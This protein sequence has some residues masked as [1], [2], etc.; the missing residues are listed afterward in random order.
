[1][2]DLILSVSS[3]PEID[4]DMFACWVEGKSVE[5]TTQLKL[6]QFKNSNNLLGLEF[7]RARENS[8]TDQSEF[9]RYEVLDQYRSF[10]ILEHYLAQPCLV[11]GQSLVI[12]T[13]VRS[14]IS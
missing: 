10:D 9:I 8:S 3:P 11:N 5:E 1:M 6:E 7:P 13:P 2:E 12:V 4:M 14:T